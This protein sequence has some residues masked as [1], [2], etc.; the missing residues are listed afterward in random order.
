MEAF[1]PDVIKAITGVAQSRGGQ[2]ILDGLRARKE[3]LVTKWL[4]NSDVNMGLHIRGKT[5]E[6]AELIK[7]FESLSQSKE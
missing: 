4:S 6:L 2:V 1:S 3:W 7:L 5:S